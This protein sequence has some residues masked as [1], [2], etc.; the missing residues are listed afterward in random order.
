MIYN[1]I[2][3]LFLHLF[4]KEMIFK[5][6]SEI[7][8]NDNNILQIFNE[9]IKEKYM[10]SEILITEKLLEELIKISIK[11][12]NLKK[13]DYESILYFIKQAENNFMRLT[14]ENFNE[15][16][17]NNFNNIGKQ[18]KVNSMTLAT[19]IQEDNH[20]TNSSVEN[21]LINSDQPDE[22]E[23]GE[24]LKL[25]DLKTLIKEANTASI[26]DVEQGLIVYKIF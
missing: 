6:V 15:I 17:S 4:F 11:I 2:N 22:K 5:I 21:L 18:L 8:L 12:C 7:D 23:N 13:Y 20:G 26:L 3:I 14:N 25:K 24:K 16:I 10:K 1:V 19:D 9:K